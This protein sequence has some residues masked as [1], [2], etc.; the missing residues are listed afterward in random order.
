MVLGE[1]FDLDREQIEERPTEA[2]EDKYPEYFAGLPV[3]AK[4]EIGKAMAR[5]KI[6]A[7]SECRLS[8]T[9]G[10][11][12]Q[13]QFCQASGAWTYPVMLH[14]ASRSPNDVFSRG[15]RPMQK[16]SVPMQQPVHAAP[17]RNIPQPGVPSIA[18]PFPFATV[19][20]MTPNIP[21]PGGSRMR[22]T[23]TS[24]LCN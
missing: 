23:R 16:G 22:R 2:Y 17:T 12:V 21:M 20:P 10:E 15:Q 9:L 18:S 14:H 5:M 13:V 11:S 7:G 24:S 1:P 19:V 6:P 3:P 4:L 8:Y